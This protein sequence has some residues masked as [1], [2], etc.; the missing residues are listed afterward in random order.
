MSESQ[1][2]QVEETK[3][4]DEDGVKEKAAE[5]SAAKVGTE[6]S[7][8]E[9][10]TMDTGGGP[11]GIQIQSDLGDKEKSTTTVDINTLTPSTPSQT[12]PQ[13][14]ASET[15]TSGV[16]AVIPENILSPPKSEIQT[17]ETNTATSTSC[18]P[19]SEGQ[20]SPVAEQTQLLVSVPG[21]PKQE[22]QTEPPTAVNGSIPKSG[23]PLSTAI[24]SAKKSSKAASSS[25]RASRARKPKALPMYESEISDNKVG[26]KLCIKKS[27]AGDGAPAAATPPVP[28]SPAAS[29]P[30]RK[31]VRKPKQADSDESE[32][33]P[34]KKKGGGGGGAGGGE[35]GNSQKKSATEAAPAAEPI[36]QSV[37][38]QKL[39]EDVLFRVS[40][41][42]KNHNHYKIYF[43]LFLL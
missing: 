35:S 17:D 29:K 9:V 4:S 25:P 38:A 41:T 42:L 36:E 15:T 7:A 14:L 5:L 1:A 34:R 32:Y 33:E 27:D 6:E 43:F 13:L 2:S 31:R 11:P 37:W 3:V 40:L 23:K 20:R 10:D 16:T 24:S 22:L 19:A 12:P 18:S 30:A 26:I 21:P 8:M 28:A 39:P